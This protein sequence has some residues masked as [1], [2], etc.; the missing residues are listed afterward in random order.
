VRLLPDQLLYDTLA[1]TTR[2]VPG[3]R[4]PVAIAE[5]DLGPV[6]LDFANEPHF[7]LFGDVQCGKSG[8]L[9]SLAQGICDRYQPNE[10]KLIMVDY[11]LSM[12]GAV[13][14]THLIGYGTSAQAT[15]DLIGQAVVVMRERLPGPEVTPEQ[16]PN[17]SWWRGPELF[18]LVDD[19]DLVATGP[20]NPLGP[21]LEFLAQGRDI[22]LHVVVS[23]L[24]GGASRAMYDPILSRIRDVASPGVVMSGPKDEG[25]LLGNVKPQLLPPGR[26]W[27]VSRR[28]GAQ[29][30]QLAWSPPA[31]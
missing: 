14:K 17:R 2:E 16:L 5:T 26:G 1:A 18:V 12:L 8:F 22:G 20:T 27:L 24:V 9:R 15:A 11:R 29:L 6:Y 3:R 4:V 10:A 21:L 7:L 30:V 23:R 28:Q 31:Q 13:A 19:Y 25:P